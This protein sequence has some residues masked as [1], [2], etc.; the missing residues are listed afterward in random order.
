MVEG[1]Q[2]IIP[3]FVNINL[4]MCFLLYTLAGTLEGVFSRI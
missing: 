1:C 4:G 3:L 2:N